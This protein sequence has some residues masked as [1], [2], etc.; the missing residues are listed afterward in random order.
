MPDLEAVQTAKRA[1]VRSLHG[2]P[3]VNGVGIGGRRPDYV[4]RV[5]IVDPDDRPELLRE[6]DGIPIE[7]VIVGRIV[8]QA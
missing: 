8:A 2:D 7:V 3:R 4:I 6:I 1:L 5:N